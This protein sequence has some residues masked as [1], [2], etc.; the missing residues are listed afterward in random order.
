MCDGIHIVYFC[1]NERDHE[2]V[3]VLYLTEREKKE[4]KKK[5]NKKPTKRNSC[6]RYYTFCKIQ[7]CKLKKISRKGLYTVESLVCG[8]Y[9]IFIATDTRIH[10]SQ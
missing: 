7:V 6:N 10:G 4:R 1:R 5:Q 3:E 8:C 2:N 9:V